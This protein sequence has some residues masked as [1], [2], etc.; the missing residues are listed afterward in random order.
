ML[1]SPRTMIIPVSKL[2]RLTASSDTC[3]NNPSLREVI[4]AMYAM[5]LYYSLL[6][7]SS[8]QCI[9]KIFINFGGTRNLSC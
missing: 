4:D 2:N 9:T 1:I 6:P 7:R 3:N 5:F 8:S